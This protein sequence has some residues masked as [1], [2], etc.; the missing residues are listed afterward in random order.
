MLAFCC[1]FLCFCHS[2]VGAEKEEIALVIG[3]ESYTDTEV[4]YYYYSV[5]HGILESMKGYESMFQLD[6]TKDLDQQKCPVSEKVESWREYLLGMALDEL[7]LNSVLYQEALK[8]EYE[9]VETANQQVKL[10]LEYQTAEAKAKG[11]DSLDE[12]LEK[13]YG[14]VTTKQLERLVEQSAVA[15]QYRNDKE[16]SLK[17]SEDELK[18]YK[19]A[20]SWNYTKY[21]YLY[22]F[23]GTDQEV[24]N[25]LKEAKDEAEFREMTKELTGKECYELLEVPGKELGNSEAQDMIW[26]AEEER[27]TGDTYI[28]TSSNNSYVLFYLESKDDSMDGGKETLIADLK[29]ETIQEWEQSLLSEY[30]VEKE[31]ALNQVGK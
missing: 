21:S 23:V 13:E 15:Y 31:A 3:Q 22:A 7:T 2:E 1:L 26:L 27:K 29:K 19:E 5:Y 11:F 8:E 17:F 30:I 16:M 12:Y 6:L 28:G 4:N 18:E 20:H 25:A 14:N 24:C 10:A 9:N